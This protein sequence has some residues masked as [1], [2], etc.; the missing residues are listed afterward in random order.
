MKQI[1]SVL[2]LKAISFLS[3]AYLCISDVMQLIDK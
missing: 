2:C 3:K 1:Q